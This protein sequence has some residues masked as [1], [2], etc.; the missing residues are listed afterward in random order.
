M[1]AQQLAG[2]VWGGANRVPRRPELDQEV[3]VLW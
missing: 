3:D 1:D 2:V